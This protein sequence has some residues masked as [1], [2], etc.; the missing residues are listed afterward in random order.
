MQKWHLP[1]PP[2]LQRVIPGFWSSNRCLKISK[3]ISFTYSLGTF[4]TAASLLSLRISESVHKPFK[5]RISVPYISIALLDISFVDF[6]I[7]M[8][9]GLVC[10]V[11]VPRIVVLD[12]EHK[13]LTP[14]GK[15]LY[16]WD[17]SWLW[18]IMPGVGFWQDWISCPSWCGTFIFC[19]GEAVKLIFRSFSEGIV[20][21]VT[22]DLLCPWE[23]ARSASSYTAIH[24]E[25]SSA[26]DLLK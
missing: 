4:Q 11:R 18:G 1:Q 5:T 25:L 23:D 10:L 12:V 2:S 17:L 22:A 21:Y 14:H 7:Q 20:P 13:P 15:A 19:C 6:Q 3:W 8:F 16:L 9:W 26:L 24:N